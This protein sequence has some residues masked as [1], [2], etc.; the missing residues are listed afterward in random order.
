MPE[1]PL[2]GKDELRTLQEPNAPKSANLL[3]VSARKV[4]EHIF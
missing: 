4:K 1:I 3:H 2:Q